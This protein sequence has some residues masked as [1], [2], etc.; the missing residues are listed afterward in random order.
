M[1]TKLYHYTPNTGD[2]RWS[3]RA[4]VSDDIVKYLQTASP[5]DLGGGFCLGYHAQTPTGAWRF[6]LGRWNTVLVRCWIMLTQEQADECWPGI[7]ELADQ[8]EVLCARTCPQLPCLAVLL[9]GTMPLEKAWLAKDRET[10]GMLGDLERCIA[11]AL[12]EK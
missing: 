12:L 5:A 4:E 3:P 6:D 8:D 9:V 2:G 11:W 7:V 10:W 1:T